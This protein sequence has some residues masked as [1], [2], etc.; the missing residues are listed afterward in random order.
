MLCVV[1]SSALAQLSS[2]PS[3]PPRLRFDRPKT[4]EPFTNKLGPSAIQSDS[5]FSNA[6]DSQRHP[7]LW[8][9]QRQNIAPN[10]YG[11]AFEFHCHYRDKA[12]KKV[13]FDT[14]W[15]YRE[16]FTV[17]NKTEASVSFL[18]QREDGSTYWDQKKFFWEAGDGG[19]VKPFPGSFG[20]ILEIQ[21]TWLKIGDS[22]EIGAIEYLVLHLMAE[23]ANKLVESTKSD[24]SKLPEYRELKAAIPQ[25]ASEIAKAND[26]TRKEQLVTLLQQVNA[27]VENAEG[28]TRS[29][30]PNEA[31]ANGPQAR[32]T[33]NENEQ[34]RTALDQLQAERDKLVEQAQNFGNKV[35]SQQDAE[36]E[37]NRNISQITKMFPVEGPPKVRSARNKAKLALMDLERA[38]FDS[39]Y[40]QIEL[41]NANKSA[42]SNPNNPG[43]A[44]Q[45]VYAQQRVF[46]AQ[47]SVKAKVIEANAA[48]KEVKQAEEVWTRDTESPAPP[49]VETSTVSRP[50]N[51]EVKA[52]EVVVNNEKEP[53]ARGGACPTKDGYVE[54]NWNYGA[55]DPIPSL[56]TIFQ[57]AELKTTQARMSGIP[58][59]Y[60]KADQ[61]AKFAIANGMWGPGNALIDLQSGKMLKRFKGENFRDLDIAQSG[62]WAAFITSQRDDYGIRV[63]NTSTLKESFYKFG[64]KPGQIRVHSDDGTALVLVLGELLHVDL[65]SGQV[66]QRWQVSN[67]VRYLAASPKFEFVVVAGDTT[68]QFMQKTIVGFSE[69]RAASASTKRM[70]P[71]RF[72]SSG[73]RILDVSVDGTIYFGADQVIVFKPQALE[74][75][76]SFNWVEYRTLEARL[77]DITYISVNKDGTMVTLCEDQ[78]RFAIVRIKT[79]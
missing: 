29:S 18:I 45:V 60:F 49:K 14:L 65:V 13:G 12:P 43:Y 20:R 54:I 36:Q 70:A 42:K 61:N 50:A 37:K 11:L 28:T 72:Y 58:V 40:W 32:F 33:S 77:S 25:L 34:L 52:Y 3:S 64:S 74:K 6:N 35:E 79:P 24:A 31:G 76:H 15:S 21:T 22:L 59:S 51:S 44:V 78:G 39:A 75:A 53:N 27:V 41:N 4:T 67:K 8:T 71:F 10:S 48:L 66:R 16:C 30:N 23:F 57:E 7:N 26:P 63:I 47:R 5:L 56:V 73:I 2:Q 17:K 1:S 55:K 38:K 9:W 62:N 19:T 69:M 46:D 68:V